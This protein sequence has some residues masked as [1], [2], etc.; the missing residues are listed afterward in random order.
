MKLHLIRHAHA[1]TAEENP[2]RPLSDRGRAQ[3]A[4][5]VAHFRGTGA[6]RPAEFWHSPLA[7]SRETADLLATGLG[8]AAPL[9]EIA[10]LEPEDDPLAI[11]ALL[12]RTTVDLALVGHEPHLSAL[13]ALLLHG[14]GTPSIFA[15]KKGAVLSLAGEN[16]QWTEQWRVAPQ[17]LG[18]E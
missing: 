2:A 5:L 9:R 17:S 13:A 11:R 18:E 16:N 14:P 15:F 1:V 7:R 6:L 12:A 10:G 3:V 4:L 8:L